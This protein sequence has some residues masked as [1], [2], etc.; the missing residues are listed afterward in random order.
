MKKS[1]QT[2][3]A[4]WGAKAFSPGRYNNIVGR[5]D[6]FLEE[7]LELLQA[8]GYPR[9]RIPV[10]VDYTYGR[11][12]GEPAQEVGGTVLTL[13][14]YCN[15]IGV[16]MEAEAQREIDRVNQPEVLAKIQAKQALKD[17][18]NFDTPLPG[19]AGACL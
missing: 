5:G 1:I 14:A 6:R 2:Q 16:D 11:P 7:V 10:L 15:V 8:N 4:E 18:I 9:E 19:N 3:V 13:A 17:A 12:V